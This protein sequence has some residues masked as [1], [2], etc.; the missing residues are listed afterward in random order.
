MREP[1]GRPDG[2]QAGWFWYIRQHKQHRQPRRGAPFDYLFKGRGSHEQL[3]EEVDACPAIKE[4]LTSARRVTGYFATKDYSYR[5][6]QAAGDGW[7][8]VGVRS[9]SSIRCTRR[10]CCWR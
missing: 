10:G 3:H 7:V 4:R 1:P 8:M 2:Q 5:S 9:A 6:T